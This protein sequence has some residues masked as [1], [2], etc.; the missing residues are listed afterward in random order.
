MEKIIYE[1][2]EVVEYY[3]GILVK[4]VPDK[5]ILANTDFINLISKDFCKVYEKSKEEGD[6]CLKSGLM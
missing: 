6:K 5:T 2:V 1:N 4:L 3:I